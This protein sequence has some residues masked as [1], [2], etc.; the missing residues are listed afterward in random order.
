MWKKCIIFF[1]RTDEKN[2]FYFVLLNRLMANKYFDIIVKSLTKHMGRLI[3]ISKV[4]QLLKNVVD[5]DFADHKLYKLIYYLKNRGYLYN[6][7]KNVFLV[8]RPEVE[9]TQQQI[10]D[11]FYWPIVKQ[12][13]N[14]FLKSNRYI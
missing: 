14:E 8:K 4:S 3:N 5:E 1:V 2:C 9:F 6:I 13:C 11:S 10:L 12:H 7:K